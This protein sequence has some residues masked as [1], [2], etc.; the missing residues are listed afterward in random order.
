MS[1]SITTR[2]RERLRGYSS[3]TG[4]RRRE[5]RQHGSARRTTSRRLS[6][7]WLGRNGAWINGQTLRANGGMV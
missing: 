4:L 2:R 7:S 3:D 1:Q 6:R 5:F